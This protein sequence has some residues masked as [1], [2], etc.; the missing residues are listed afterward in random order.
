M[1][2]GR[3]ATNKGPLDAL[4]AFTLLRG[5]MPEAQMWF[6]GDGPVA[7]TLAARTDPNVTLFGRVSRAERDRLLARA[8]VLVVT[9][10]R[11]GWGL[12]VDEAA[13]M[14]TPVIGYDRP[15]LRDS[16]P[17]ARGLLVPPSPAALAEALERMLP[18]WTTAPATRGWVGGARDWDTV[19]LAVRT[20]L[21]ISTGF[22]TTRSFDADA[23]AGDGGRT[24]QELRADVGGVPRE[25]PS[26]NVSAS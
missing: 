7:P 19:A 23:S 10:V 4:E 20:E 2:L 16:V 25:R 14:G 24:D 3:L 6:V 18:E 21:M 8:H 9:S 11:E 26:P 17:A 5:R 12:V 15:G 22:E 1:F 13:A